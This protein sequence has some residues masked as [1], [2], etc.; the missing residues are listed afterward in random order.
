MLL[1]FSICIEIL[2]RNQNSDDKIE[3]EIEI[4]IST[5]KFQRQSKFRFRQRNRNF[6]QS[7][8]RNFDEIRIKFRRNFDFVECKNDF[9]GNPTEN[10]PLE[11]HDLILPYTVEFTE[12][13]SLKVVNG[14]TFTI[15]Y[16]NIC[17]FQE[18]LSKSAD[19]PDRLRKHGQGKQPDILYHVF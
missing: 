1:S 6:G 17:P 2:Y 10:L 8:H 9:R 11:H 3:T 12:L 14:P 13:Y 15:N 19:E 16:I 5:S 18:E 4:P 7:K